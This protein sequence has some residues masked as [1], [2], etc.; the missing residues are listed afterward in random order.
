LNRGSSV[1]LKQI[2]EPAYKVD[3]KA[4]GAGGKYSFR[5]DAVASGETVLRLIYLRPWEE[6]A[7]PLKVFEVKVTVTG[8]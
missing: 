5:F 8:K 1:V 3:S 6:K 7:T 4:V 2:R